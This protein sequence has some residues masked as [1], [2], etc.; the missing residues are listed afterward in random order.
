MRTPGPAE[1]EVAEL[2]FGGKVVDGVLDLGSRVSRKND[3]MK[4]G[5]FPILS[6][7]EFKPRFLRAEFSLAAQ[8]CPSPPLHATVC[9][10]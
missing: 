2:A 3:F 4:N 7:P 5:V 8:K 9:H 1:A 6:N 10:G